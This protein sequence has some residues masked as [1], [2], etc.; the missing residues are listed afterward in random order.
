MIELYFK[1]KVFLQI[2]GL[3]IV[4]LCILGIIIW[5]I[6]T[7]II[8]TKKSSY[9]KS[10]GFRYELYRVSSIGGRDTYVYVRDCTSERIYDYEVR[11]NKL[12]TLKTKYKKI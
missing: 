9:L 5:A 12:K 3:S 1:I 11:S 7:S 8:D 6:V 2:L 4:I 10:I